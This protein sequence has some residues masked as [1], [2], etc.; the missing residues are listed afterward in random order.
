[1]NEN[2]MIKVVF[3]AAAGTAV[4]VDWRVFRLL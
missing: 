4:W 1:M 3:Q 2:P